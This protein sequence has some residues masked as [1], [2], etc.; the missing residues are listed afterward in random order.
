MNKTEIAYKEILKVLKKYKDDIVFDVDSLEE[1]SKNHLFGVKLVEKYG[2]KLNPRCIYSTDW[3]ELKSNVFI[4]FYDGD[5]R[6]KISW[7]DK[8]KQP[9]N[10]TLLCI[11]FPTGAYIFGEDYPTDIFNDFFNELKTY[12]PKYVDTRNHSLYFSLNNGGKV[13][14][15]YDSIL[16]KY[17]NE[18]KTKAKEREI[19]KLKEQLAILEN[20]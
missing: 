13:F 12:K 1:K 17:H 19:K 9:K 7:E 6:R 2:F 8:D 16:E 5:N 3:Q 10:E 15:D 20:K 11:N 14:N 4:G 18:Y